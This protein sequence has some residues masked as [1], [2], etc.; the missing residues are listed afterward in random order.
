MTLS[1]ELTVAASDGWWSSYSTMEIAD[2]TIPAGQKVNVRLTLSDQL[3]I[4]YFE[5]TNKA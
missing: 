1:G 4:D 5:L 2:I 3:N